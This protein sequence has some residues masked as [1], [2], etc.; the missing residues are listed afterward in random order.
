MYYS[1]AIA[2]EGELSIG[3][4]DDVQKLHIRTILLIEQARS[5]FHQEQ[6]MTRC[7]AFSSTPTIAGES[8]AKIHRLME[9]WKIKSA[10]DLEDLKL[11]KILKTYNNWW[12]FWHI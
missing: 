9:V 6:S 8:F 5:I 1:L 11:L 3:S 12:L 2:E 7:F 4:I 10:E